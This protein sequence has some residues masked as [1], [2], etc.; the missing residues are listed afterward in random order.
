MAKLFHKRSKTGRS[1]RR[2]RFNNE[3]IELVDP[4]LYRGGLAE[5]K[6]PTLP[7]EKNRKLEEEIENPLNKR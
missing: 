2:S 1:Q 3:K 6:Y 5:E 4:V 7:L